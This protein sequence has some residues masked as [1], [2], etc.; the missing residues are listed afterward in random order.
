[1]KRIYE[2]GRAEVE[3]R[4]PLQAVWKLFTDVEA[5]SSWMPT[6]LSVSRLGSGSFE[7]GA[8]YRVRQPGLPDTIYTV[9]SIDDQS[10]FTWQARTPGAVLVASHEVW[11]APAGCGARSIYAASGVLA[12][13]IR[14]LLGA[15]IARMLE[16]EADSLRQRAEQ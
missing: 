7:I 5:W 3:I 11:A 4:A 9:T 16:Q 6:I 2:C 10:A 1:M 8:R 13:T 12:P 14:F 15:R